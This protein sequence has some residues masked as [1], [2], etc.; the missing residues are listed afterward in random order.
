MSL[1]ALSCILTPFGSGGLE[2]GSHQVVVPKTLYSLHRARISRDW[3][4]RIGPRLSRI[5]ALAS[6]FSGPWSEGT[7]SSESR[8]CAG[9][10]GTEAKVNEINKRRSDGRNFDE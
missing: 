1:C 10:E 4:P 8:G 9:V 6:W 2:P 5:D 7:P 3:K